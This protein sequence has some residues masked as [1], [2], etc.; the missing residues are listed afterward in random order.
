MVLT[1]F[2]YMIE[3]TRKDKLICNATLF[4][5]H[6]TECET[7]LQVGRRRKWKQLEICFL[8]KKLAA[9]VEENL[10][11]SVIILIQLWIM[12]EHV[13]NAIQRS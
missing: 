11:A 6:Y 1:A 9:Y 13:M 8:M 5:I 2:S 3:S 7:T 12:E 4:H 10:L